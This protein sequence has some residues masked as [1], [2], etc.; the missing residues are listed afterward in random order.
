MKL[1]DAHVALTWTLVPLP[2]L[3]LITRIFLTDSAK[4]EIRFSQART[5]PVPALTWQKQ[6]QHVPGCPHS[7]LLQERDNDAEGNSDFMFLTVFQIS[8]S[9]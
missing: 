4:G 7:I 6:L 2:P 5:V 9:C 3:L 1:V 8:P